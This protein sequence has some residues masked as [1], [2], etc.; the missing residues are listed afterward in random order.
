M[1]CGDSKV[2]GLPCCPLEDSVA[3]IVRDQPMARDPRWDEG[4]PW[5]LPL[6]KRA[7]AVPTSM[8]DTVTGLLCWAATQ[9]APLDTVKGT[10]RN[11]MTSYMTEDRQ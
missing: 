4:E 3:A 11:K 8:R 5:R 10:Q 9:Q 6:V 2:V 7:W 1:H